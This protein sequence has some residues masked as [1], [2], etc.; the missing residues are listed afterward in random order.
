VAVPGV[1]RKRRP[2]P[3]PATA[4]VAVPYPAPCRPE[5]GSVE[6]CFGSAAAAKSFVLA[7]DCLP[8][9]TRGCAVFLPHRSLIQSLRLKIFQATNQTE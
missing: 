6:L 9:S 8:A 5:L 7:S 2:L 1:S 4:P 3:H